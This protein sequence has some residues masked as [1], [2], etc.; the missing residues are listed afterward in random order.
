MAPNFLKAGSDTTVAAL[1]NFVLL[2]TLHPDIQEQARKE[3]D[4]VV[5]YDR[6][7]SFN[8]KQSMPYLTAVLKEVLRSV[9]DTCP[10]AETD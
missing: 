2:M 4:M 7:P 5:G 1:S 6:F 8:D 3:V 9:P 10:L